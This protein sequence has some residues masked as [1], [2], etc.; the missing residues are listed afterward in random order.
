M[1]GFFVFYTRL[2]RNMQTWFSELVC[3][4]VVN[5]LVAQHVKSIVL[6]VHWSMYWHHTLGLR[7]EYHK[8]E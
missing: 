1:T 2:A 5:R 4:R 7:S 3:M 8:L 6:T